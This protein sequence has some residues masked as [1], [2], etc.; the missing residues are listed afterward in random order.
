L[1]FR[2]FSF[3]SFELITDKQNVE[4][5]GSI[6]GYLIILLLAYGLTGNQTAY[7]GFCRL[8]LGLFWSRAQITADSQNNT[9]SFSNIGFQFNPR[10]DCAIGESKKFH[11]IVPSEIGYYFFAPPPIQT[12]SNPETIKGFVG[13]GLEHQGDSI[14]MAL[15]GGLDKSSYFRSENSQT[16]NMISVLKPRISFDLDWYA[17]GGPGHDIVVNIY[18]GYLLSGSNSS[19]SFEY[20]GGIIYGAGLTLDLGHSIL[21]F[22][23]SARLMKTNSWTNLGNQNESL[24]MIGIEIYTF[25]FGSRY[26]G[27]D[28]YYRNLG[29]P[30]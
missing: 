6:I 3:Y 24:L 7:A 5:R 27:F 1:R 25:I 23:I 17:L 14:H 18:T 9:E 8:E 30:P 19:E 4:K 12:I 26:S 16:L 13:L 15:Y 21:P 22:A 28:H 10:F 20:N 29:L 11:F 2:R